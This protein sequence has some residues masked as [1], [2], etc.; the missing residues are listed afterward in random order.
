MKKNKGFTLVEMI[1]ALGAVAVVLP[2]LFA[3]FFIILREQIKSTSLQTVL[4]NST[5]TLTNIRNLVEKQNSRIL[6][7]I[8]TDSNCS[9]KICNASS[10]TASGLT[11]IYM[12]YFDDNDDATPDLIGII[13]NSTDKKISILE[14]PTNQSAATAVLTSNQVNVESFS[15]GCEFVDEN[16]I[17]LNLKFRS[18]FAE[19][20]DILEK[21]ASMEFSTAMRIIPNKREPPDTR[22]P[23]SP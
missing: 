16:I 12:Q 5:K 9:N 4:N 1:A 19:G 10:T 17:L 2:A 23:P 18:D 3:S 15:L 6:K 8:C 11:S 21:Q 20:Q 13:Y 7:Y 22:P 14:K